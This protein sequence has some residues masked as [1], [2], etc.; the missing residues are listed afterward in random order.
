MLTDDMHV[1]CTKRNDRLVS[2][3]RPLM[4][5]RGNGSSLTLRPPSLSLSL[6]L[7]GPRCQ[8]RRRQRVIHLAV[9]ICRPRAR[10]LICDLIRRYSS[11][12]PTLTN[13]CLPPFSKESLSQGRRGPPR[14]TQTGEREIRYV[15]FLLITILGSLPWTQ[16]GPLYYGERGAFA[17]KLIIRLVT[18]HG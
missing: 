13:I 7:C 3:T 11:S 4:G 6:S 8:I 5:Q 14:V 9:L 15:C 2:F 10:V 17:D 18:G 12:T 16:V 1:E